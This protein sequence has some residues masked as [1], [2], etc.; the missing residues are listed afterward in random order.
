M[1]RR[2]PEAVA[3]GWN[4]A[5]TDT[6]TQLLLDYDFRSEEALL[7]FIQIVWPIV[8]R[9][10]FQFGKLQL[11]DLEAMR[12]KHG[13]HLYL[14]VRNKMRDLDR[15]F[16]QLMLGSDFK[17]ELFNYRRVKLG[18][19]DWNFLFRD[20]Y[21]ANHEL[22]YVE[23]SMPQLKEKIVSKMSQAKGLRL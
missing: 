3:H 6:M 16:V 11:T 18:E 21:D 23:K 8:F 9:F 17:R 20:R 22:I 10:E 13:W 5:E 14:E 7:K 15:V 2:L 19:T 1:V 4:F 12:T